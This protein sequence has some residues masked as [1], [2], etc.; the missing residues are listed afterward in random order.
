MLATMPRRSKSRIDD[1]MH[2][3]HPLAQWRARHMITQV[4]LSKACR[5][6]QGQ[7]SKIETFQ[8]LPLRDVLERL[9]DYTGL[10]TDAFI[11]PKQFLD[12]HPDFLAETTPPQSPRI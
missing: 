7:L 11:R 8:Q 1:P 2:W 4:Q 12:E 5:M 10:P 3:P 6:S 9:R